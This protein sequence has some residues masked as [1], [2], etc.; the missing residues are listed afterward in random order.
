MFAALFA[1]LPPALAFAMI[2]LI[3]E[4]ALETI[5]KTDAEKNETLGAF[6]MPAL[7]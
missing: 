5:L 6:T 4:F 3:A 2:P 1:A 7:A